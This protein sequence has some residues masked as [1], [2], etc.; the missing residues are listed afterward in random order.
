MQF[1]NRAEVYGENSSTFQ[2]AQCIALKMFPLNRLFSVPDACWLYQMSMSI[3]YLCSKNFSVSLSCWERALMCPAVLWCWYHL[4]HL[5]AGCCIL[6]SRH[7]QASQPQI[8]K[9]FFAFNNSTQLTSKMVTL[10]VCLPNAEHLSP[11]AHVT[12]DATDSRGCAESAVSG[13]SRD[14]G[15]FMMWDVNCDRKEPPSCRGTN[16]PGERVW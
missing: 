5:S 13:A 11:L 6:C 7:I 3:F 4:P 2:R 8:W 10:I 14:G 15:D 1:L 12:P 9:P 16:M